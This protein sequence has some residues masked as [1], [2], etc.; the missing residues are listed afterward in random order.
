MSWLIK[1]LWS[2]Y[3]KIERVSYSSCIHCY[4]PVEGKIFSMR[5][6]SIKRGAFTAKFMDDEEPE[7]LHLFENYRTAR[8]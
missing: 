1:L 7:C 3:R 8:Q 4:F 5:V 2:F 6:S